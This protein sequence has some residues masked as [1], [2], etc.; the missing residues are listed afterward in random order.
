MKHASS[1]MRGGDGGQRLALSSA[2][3][4]LLVN[5][6]TLGADFV[7]D[8][9]VSLAPAIPGVWRTPTVPDYPGCRYA[10][11]RDLTGPALLFCQVAILANRDVWGNGTMTELFSNDFWGTSFA[12]ARS[13]RCYRPLTVLTFRANHRLQHWLGL[14]GLDPL[15]FHAVN[16]L[17]AAACVFLAATILHRLCSPQTGW[18]SRGQFSYASAVGSF[19]FAV[20]PLHSEAIA[21]V[22]GRADLLAANF[23]FL[24]VLVLMQHLPAIHPRSR[25][26]QAGDRPDRPIVG[27]WNW[28]GV[29]LPGLLAVTAGLCKETGLTVL[30]I[31]ILVVMCH[32]IRGCRTALGVRDN[33]G[34]GAGKQQG[35]RANCT[36]DSDGRGVKFE[37]RGRGGEV[38]GHGGACIAAADA[39]RCLRAG[40]AVSAVWVAC[41]AGFVTHRIWLA[42]VRQ[43]PIKRALSKR[44]RT[45]KKRP[46]KEPKSS[47]IQEPY[48]LR[49]LQKSPTK[50]LY[51]TQKITEK[52]PF[53]ALLPQGQ[54]TNLNFH[55]IDN[56][57][58]PS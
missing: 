18:G 29:L 15:G 40:M 8:D 17:C 3:L 41:G 27:E 13:H 47:V 32:A 12:H 54:V 1:E 45:L 50:E 22:V 2:V 10:R 5:A 30:A 52:K 6:N 33:V 43:K 44:L 7:M 20:H 37:R 53:H 9:T 56:P 34:G 49:V 11:W 55:H 16:V 42:Q 28:R 21:S 26:E 25:T 14:S 31:L 51:N 39:W 46:R 36:D 58:V 19:L 57:L 4:S 48:I 23:A 38:V 35:G 24:S